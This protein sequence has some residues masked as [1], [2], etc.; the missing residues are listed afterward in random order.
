MGDATATSDGGEGVLAQGLDTRVNIDAVF[1][2]PTS[3]GVSINQDASGTVSATVTNPRL[4]AVMVDAATTERVHIKYLKAENCR[5][6]SGVVVMDSECGH[7][8]PRRNLRM[9]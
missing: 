7:H 1:D 9:Q 6:G 8:Q 2:A 4:G 5:E 3:F